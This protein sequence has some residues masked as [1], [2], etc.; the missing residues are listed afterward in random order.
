MMMMKFH[1]ELNSWEFLR[2]PKNFQKTENSVYKGRQFVIW[3]TKH[4]MKC[5]KKNAPFDVSF[6]VCV[7]YSNHFEFGALHR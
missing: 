6:F 1:I 5:S 4:L 3:L 2:I 7:F